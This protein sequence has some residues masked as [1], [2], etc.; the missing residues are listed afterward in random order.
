LIESLTDGQN[1]ARRVLVTIAVC[2][3][4]ALAIAATQTLFI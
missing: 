4:A 3:R 2:V 1:L